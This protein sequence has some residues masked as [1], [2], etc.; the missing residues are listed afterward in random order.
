MA[1]LT[2]STDLSRDWRLLA[3]VDNLTD[4]DYVSVKGYATAGRTFYLGLSW[5]PR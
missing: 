2:A 4:K 1:H 5:S 3:R